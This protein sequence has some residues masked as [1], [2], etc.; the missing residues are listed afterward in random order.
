MAT[1]MSVCATITKAL[2]EK[3]QSL[4]AKLYMAEKERDDLQIEVDLLRKKI[5]E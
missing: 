5:I 2:V 4:E 3:I 1:E